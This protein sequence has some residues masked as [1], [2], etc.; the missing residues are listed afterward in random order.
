MRPLRKIA[1]LLEEF[2]VPT[3]AQQLLDRFLIGYPREGAFHK[4]DGTQI[5]AYVAVAA[6][7][8]FGERPKEFDLVVA[9]TMERAVTDADAVMIVSRRPGDLANEAF[10]KIAVEQA[11]EG[12]ACFVHGALANTLDSARQYSRTAA[13]RRIALRSGTPLS[14][15]WRLPP[16]ELPTGTP[17][18]E[19]LIVVQVNPLDSPAIPPSPPVTLGGAV[20][21]ALDGLLPVI[22]RRRGGESGIRSVRFLEGKNLWRAGEK[23]LWSWPLLGAALSRSHSPQGDA[24]RDGRTQDIVGLGLVPKLARHPRGWLLEHRDGLRTAILVLDGVVADFNFA[25]RAPNGDIVSAQL[26]RGPPPAEHHFSR[27]AAVLEDFFRSSQPPWPLERSLL[28][29]GLLETF[30]EPSSLSGHRVETPDL[31]IAYTSS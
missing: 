28:V 23:G 12:A 10:V 4:L 19:A 25:V 15:G 13:A 24:V 29:T 21:Q 26:F 8:S 20:L 11:P 17:L 6:E 18:A 2:G 22:E 9:P 14:V 1:F 7:S 5:A 31:G 30:A 27:L 16:V 3:P